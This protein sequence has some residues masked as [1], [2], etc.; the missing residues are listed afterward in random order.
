MKIVWKFVS[1]RS[2]EVNANVIEILVAL[3]FQLI[4]R[5]GGL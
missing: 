4:V 2:V 3:D 5:Q 1:I